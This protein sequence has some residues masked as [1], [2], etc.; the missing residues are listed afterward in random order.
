MSLKDILNTITIIA[1]DI[2]ISTPYICGGLPRDKVMNREMVIEDVDITNGDSSIK[3]LA[4]AV[5]V[6]FKDD[7]SNFKQLPDGHSQL[8][9]NGV[10]FDFST[11]YIQPGVKE[12]LEK[13]GMKNPIPMQQELYSRDFTCNALLMTMDLK[14]VIDPTGLGLTDIKDKILR[15]CLPS[16]ITLGCDDKRVVRVIYMA[17]KLGFNVDDEIINWVKD[18]PQSLLA[19]GKSDYVSKK[20]NKALDYNSEITVKL[21][22]DMGLWPYVPVTEKLVPYISKGVL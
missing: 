2:G 14:K 20:I 22:G 16:K 4:Q 3:E 12:M 13:A 11:N 6:K 15:T 18:N 10:K 8:F 7:D 17:A 19:N 5:S 9:L 1:K 21:I